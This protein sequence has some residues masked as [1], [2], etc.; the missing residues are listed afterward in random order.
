[1]LQELKL[2]LKFYQYERTY[3][4][5]A[6]K[7]AFLVQWV[8]GQTPSPLLGQCPNFLTFLL[9]ASEYNSYFLILNNPQIPR[10]SSLITWYGSWRPCA[11]LYSVHHCVITKQA[12]D[13]KT[14]PSSE[15]IR[16]YSM[17]LKKCSI[18]IESSLKHDSNILC[19]CFKHFWSKL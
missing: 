3:H 7:L 19:V 5:S 1:M 14:R 11:W 8:D 12:K 18:S 6:S 13:A 9:M 10:T 17:L 16:Y 2:S 15:F 4:L